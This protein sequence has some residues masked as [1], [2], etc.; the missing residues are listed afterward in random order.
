[1]KKGDEGFECSLGRV[2]HLGSIRKRRDKIVINPV[3]FL[4]RQV[5]W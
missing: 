3:F 5:K 4:G 2:C 1:M